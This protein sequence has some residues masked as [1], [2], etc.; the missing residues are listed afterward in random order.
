MNIESDYIR[1]D[2]LSKKNVDSI[3]CNVNVNCL[4]WLNINF[5]RLR[6]NDEWTFE[7]LVLNAQLTT[8]IAVRWC[9]QVKLCHCEKRNDRQRDGRKSVKKSK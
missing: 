1:N 8:Y 2:S 7:Q 5:A 6:K 3:E 4:S 9:V